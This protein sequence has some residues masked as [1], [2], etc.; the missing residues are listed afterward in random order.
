MLKNCVHN[1]AIEV[2]KQ[3]M[4]SSMINT[5]NSRTKSSMAANIPITMMN[6]RSGKLRS[7]T[8]D[9]LYFRS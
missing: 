8:I 5:I 1:E 2:S 3:S 4:A 6:T 7:F 9:F